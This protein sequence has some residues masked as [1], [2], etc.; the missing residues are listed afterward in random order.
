MIQLS[1]VKEVLKIQNEA[2]YKALCF[3]DDGKN[4]ALP[5]NLAPLVEEILEQKLHLVNRRIN[6]TKR[7][8]Q[9]LGVRDGLHLCM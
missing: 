2:V 9:I 7:A 8:C 1:E 3:D 6:G 4:I 5:V